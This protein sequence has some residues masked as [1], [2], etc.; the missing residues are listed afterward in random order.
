MDTPMHFETRDAFRTWLVKHGD[1]SD[2]VWLLFG[3][4]G[5][6]TTLTASEALQEALCHGWIDGQM[7]RIDDTC[8]RKYFARRRKDSHW[9]AKNKGIAQELINK[10][11]MTAAGMQAIDLAKQSGAWDNAP[12]RAKAS[13]DM[14]AALSALVKGHEPAYENFASMSPS[15]QGTYA[16]FYFDAKSEATRNARLEK[17]LDRLARN[18]KPM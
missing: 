2:G 12:A 15:V 5:G 13:G 18:L 1:T 17:I 14:V 9:S 8:Y 11:L 4:K 10:G 3:K 16:S 6:P 7:Q